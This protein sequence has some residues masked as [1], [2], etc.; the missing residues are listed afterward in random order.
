MKHLLKYC[1]VLLL[2]NPGNAM[3]FSYANNDYN[4]TV[5]QNVRIVTS[6]YEPFVMFKD[7]KLVGF[8]IDLINEICKQNHLTYSI[9][10]T[11]FQ[12]IFTQ[13]EKGTADMAI[14]CIYVTEEREE[15]F[16]FSKSYLEGG[17]VLVV[18]ANS[19]IKTIYELN[20]K[21]LGVKKD[22][23]GDLFA[24]K[25]V[26][27]GYSIEII[28]YQDTVDSFQA[29]VNGSVD[30]V[31][32]DY[33]NSVYL[34]NKY[35]SGDIKIVRGRWSDIIY[36]RRGIAYPISSNNQHLYEIINK[37]I[38]DLKSSN[39]IDMLYWKW[40]AIMP[41]PNIIRRVMIYTGL[42]AVS[43]GITCLLFLHFNKRKKFKELS[44]IEEHFRNLINDL[45]VA[46]YIIQDNSIVLSNHEGAHIAG[47]S[48]ESIIGYPLDYLFSEYTVINDK[49]L[50]Y[51]SFTDLSN[52]VQAGPMV[53]RARWKRKDGTVLDVLFRIRHVQWMGNSAL[54]CIV[55]DTT[56][57]NRLLV[58]REKLKGQ[59]LQ[60]QKLEIVGQ[61]T[62][63]IA[64]DF[65][66]IL[67]VIL[68]YANLLEASVDAKNREAVT[69]IIEAGN[70]A[71]DIVSKMLTFARKKV[72]LEQKM[73]LHH[74]IQNSILLLKTAL[75]KSCT[76]DMQLHA[77]VD[78][79]VG[80]TTQIQ[81][82]LMNL[83]INASEAMPEGGTINIETTN[84]TIEHERIGKVETIHAGEYI[85][86][87]IKDSGIGIAE[88]DIEHIFEPLFTTKEKGSGFGLS[89]VYGI[90]KQHKGY[91][92]V[93]SIPGKG[94]T[95]YIY[96]PVITENRV[97]ASL[98][99]IDNKKESLPALGGEIVIIDDD[100]NIGSLYK[101]SLHLAGLHAVTFINAEEAFDYIRTHAITVKLIISDVMMP[102]ISGEQVLEYIKQ[103]YPEIPV[104]M[105][106]GYYDENMRELL[107]EKGAK[108]VWE[109]MYKIDEIIE[110][111]KRVLSS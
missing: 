64:H 5:K 80:D 59:L 52:M 77:T 90:V 38:H 23:T 21:K 48:I 94:S 106:S 35:F 79:I 55:N 24:S 37:S 2:M 18:P 46:V 13:I 76:V 29:L 101:E 25:I 20:N 100:A 8:D 63:G 65:N 71:R 1:C 60:S 32:N 22:A 74:I 92:D 15:I 75:P 96:L 11:S 86:L 102:G 73:H 61:I 57:I 62:G 34:L 17:L 9:T 16:Q 6:L 54:E 51:S 110:K 81:Q 58:E 99:I 53:Y 36:G 33:L 93:V 109:K 78:T 69:K 41:P 111:V 30:A 3:A 97:E 108:D 83:V 45:N 87:S 105:I 98:K 27:K 14:G 7:G 70:H 67:T 82:M 103:H 104:V 56:D 91:I 95:F 85:L 49:E 12:D 50:H 19:D 40:F 4:N 66:N 26:Q 43:I 10:I 72:F 84:V 42:V 28:R 47:S 88:K 68:G 107:I 44:M 89:I 31:L 39:F